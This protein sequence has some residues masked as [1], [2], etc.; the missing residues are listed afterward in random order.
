MTRTEYMRTWVAK[1]RTRHLE[2][3]RRWAASETG[4]ASKSESDKAYYLQKKAEME[5]TRDAI[6]TM[7]GGPECRHCGEYPEGKLLHLDHIDPTTKDFNLSGW[8]LVQRS[9]DELVAE[10]LKCQVLCAACH[11]LKS[12]EDLR[13]G[14]RSRG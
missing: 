2:N 13:N 4:K 9:W 5:E 3:R 7:L 8:N 14:I 1:N 6:I 10:A 11:R 12:A